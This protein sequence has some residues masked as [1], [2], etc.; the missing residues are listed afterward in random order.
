MKMPSVMRGSSRFAR[1][2][3]VG[4]QRS[5]F[6]RSHGH[7]TTFDAGYLIPVLVDEVLP[8]DTF[9]C[10]MTAFCRLSTTV[11]PIMDNLWLDTFFFFVPNRLLWENWKQF[12]GEQ[13]DPGDTISFSVP[14]IPIAA[15]G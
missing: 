9:N 7:K 11:K 5:V 14:Q 6:D 2:P 10:R 4:A 8:G 12:C 15:G 13:E 3:Q 1:V